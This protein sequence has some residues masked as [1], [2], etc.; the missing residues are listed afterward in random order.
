MGH[1]TPKWLTLKQARAYSGL[2]PNTL[3]K[4]ADEEIIASARTEGGHRR[5]DRESID[6]YFQRD[7]VDALAIRRVISL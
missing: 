4:Y 6:S 7:E 3:R 5:Y 1:I 2:C